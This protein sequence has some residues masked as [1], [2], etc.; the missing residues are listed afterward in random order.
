MSE[1]KPEKTFRIGSVSA[2]IWLNE[3]DE[4]RRFYSTDLVRNYRDKE[5]DEW[6]SSTSYSHDELLN[7]GKL[8]ERAEEWIA[9]R[10]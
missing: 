5:T 7:V 6:K 10:S 1:K 2:T 3:T 9:H 8:A 4:G